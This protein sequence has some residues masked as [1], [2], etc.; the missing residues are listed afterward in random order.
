MYYCLF[1]LLKIIY[2][3]ED[4]VVLANNTDYLCEADKLSGISCATFFFSVFDFACSI[5]FLLQIL[6]N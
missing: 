4:N 5:F 2:F 1:I 3:E 6:Y